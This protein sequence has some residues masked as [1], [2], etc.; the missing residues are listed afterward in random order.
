MV[1]A[2]SLEPRLVPIEVL[3]AD[4]R[5]VLPRR[6]AEARVERPAELAC[7]AEAA[8]FDDFLQ[9]A[10]VATV[11]QQEPEGLVEPALQQHR[12]NAAFCRQQPVERRTREVG[13]SR[14]L[15]GPE[16]RVGKMCVDVI[17]RGLPL[18]L[19]TIQ[20]VACK[21]HARVRS[22]QCQDS[23]DRCFGF[24]DH[25]IVGLRIEFLHRCTNQTCRAAPARKDET[26]RLKSQQ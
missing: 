25:Q 9:R 16:A 19:H 4:E 5:P 11:L 6:Q 18:R 8:A 7:A 26:V 24:T 13:R 3:T 14:N 2:V 21:P 1:K 20:F 15:V 23:L 10:L 12:T 17:E 22:R